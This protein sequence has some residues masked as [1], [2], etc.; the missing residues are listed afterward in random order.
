MSPPDDFSYEVVEKDKVSKL[1]G[2]QGFDNAIISDMNQ[3]Y[4]PVLVVL[5]KKNDKIVG[6]A[7]ACNQRCGKLV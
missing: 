7:G 5:A 4:H 6:M 2:L 1:L 3:P